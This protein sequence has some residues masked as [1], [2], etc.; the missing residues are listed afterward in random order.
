MEN[1]PFRERGRERSR[2]GKAGKRERERERTAH[3]LATWK[4]GEKAQYFPQEKAPS[5][6]G[7]RG[8][9][10]LD[11]H[12]PYHLCC[13]V[14]LPTA[15]WLLP[16]DRQGA[17]TCTAGVLNLQCNW[18]EPRGPAGSC[19]VTTVVM[20][21]M[22]EAGCSCH[23]PGHRG[24]TDHPPQEGSSGASTRASEGQGRMACRLVAAPAPSPC[25]PCR[26]W[27]RRGQE[28]GGEGGEERLRP[29]PDAGTLLRWSPGKAICPDEQSQMENS[30]SQGWCFLLLI[31]IRGEQSIGMS[32]LF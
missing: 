31:I 11:P 10:C 32:F 7:G 2:R 25:G 27:R 30:S 17:R 16:G 28:K 14:G 13:P 15:S 5:S 8:R 4:L 1:H 23:P 19:T 9:G 21:T 22:L 29:H 3:T 26:G 18:G 6:E 12:N 20:T 24:D